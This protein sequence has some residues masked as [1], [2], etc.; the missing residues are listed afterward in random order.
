MA[1]PK[2]NRQIVFIM[3]DTQRADMV[4]CY[5][6]TG[7]STPNID[8]LA[9]SGMRFDKAYTCSPVCAPA[10]SALFTGIWPHA[11]GVWGNDMP[12]GDT[13]KTLGQRLTVEGVHCAY[14]GKW[15]LDGHDYFGTGRCPDGWDEEYWYDMRNY[16]D[17]LS[18]EERIASRKY[19]S[20]R[21]GIPREFTFANRCSNRAMDFLAKHGKDDFCLVVSY[22]EPHGPYLCPQPY[23]DEY[24]DFEFPRSPNLYDNLED[25]PEH[26]KVWGRNRL[27]QTQRSIPAKPDF[28]GC[29][30]FVDDEIGRVV[31]AV[32]EIVPDAII[33]YTSDHGD[34]LGS[35]CLTQKGPAPYEE[36]LRIPLIIR[37]PGVTSPARVFTQPVSH[38]DLLPTIMEV[39]GCDIP[40]TIDG[41]SIY[42]QLISPDHKTGRKIFFEFGRFGNI[43]DGA[44]GFQPFRGA[45]DGRYKLCINL[46][47]SDELYD[48]Q[49]DPDEMHNLIAAPGTSAI[50]NH[51]HDEILT[52]MNESRDP[53]RGYYWECRPW[54]NDARETTWHYTQKRRYKASDPGDPLQLDYN[55]GEAVPQTK[56]HYPALD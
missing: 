35:H 30:S 5:S 56:G 14:I 15:H 4:N 6:E 55:N 29:N 19:S 12:L 39:M 16:L 42:E 33:I 8:K 54:R 50:R 45:F 22:D 3:T 28:F 1:E 37:W 23:A 7:L 13:V 49:S 34:M 27:R 18:P 9:S 11:N 31:K 10:R 52:W 20:N 41:S 38:I 51:L 26:Q 40:Q 43:N 24:M 25:K 21:N 44:G 32:E 46:L 17:E 36:V 48:L 47:S 2:T 53:F